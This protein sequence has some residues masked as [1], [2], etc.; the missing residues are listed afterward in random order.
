MTIVLLAFFF[1]LMLC[2]VALCAESRFRREARLPMQWWLDGEVTWSAPRRMALAFIP[3]LSILVFVSLAVLLTLT[4][5]R[6]GQESMAIP[7]FL[8]VGS[9]FLAAQLFHLWMVAKTIQRRGS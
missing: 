4:H 6:P 1:G 8:A 2:G 9:I 7:S 3:A 5:P